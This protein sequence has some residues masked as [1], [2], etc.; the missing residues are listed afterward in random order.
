M[1]QTVAKVFRSA[2]EEHGLSLRQLAERANVAHNAV[3]Q[4]EGAV[5]EP[6]RERLNEW[7]FGPDRVLSDIAVAVLVERFRE[8]LVGAQRPVESVK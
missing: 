1:S 7:L 8:M 3:V 6:E 2:R 4:W 5:A